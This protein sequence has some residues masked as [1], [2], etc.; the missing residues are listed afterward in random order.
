[1]PR[2]SQRKRRLHTPPSAGGLL[3]SDGPDRFPNPHGNPSLGESCRK[4][5]RKQSLTVSDTSI[6]DD[7]V[8]RRR[9]RNCYDA[10]RNDVSRGRWLEALVFGASLHAPSLV[11]L[12]RQEQDGWRAMRADS[13]YFVADT[14]PSTCKLHSQHWYYH[15]RQHD[16]RLESLSTVLVKPVQ[17]REKSCELLRAMILTH[18]NLTRRRALS[19]IRRYE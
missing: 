12:S 9:R 14:Y 2:Q 5:R 15:L 17:N 16:G 3:G 8:W 7:A 6:D 1:M 13:R 18:L 11:A 19:S 10:L 4:G